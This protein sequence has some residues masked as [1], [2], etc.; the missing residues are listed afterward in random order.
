MSVTRGLYGARLITARNGILGNC[1]SA[2]L[3]PW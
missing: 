3:H 2:L 1:P